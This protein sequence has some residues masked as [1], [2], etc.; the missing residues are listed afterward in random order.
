[1]RSARSLRR[2]CFFV[3]NSK[4]PK[5]PVAK[6]ILSYFLC[7]PEA[8]DS[9]TEIARWRLTQE[10]VRRTVED[11]QAALDWLL[12]EGYVRE[13]VRAGTESLFR[14]NSAS[15]KEAELFLE[16]G[17]LSAHSPE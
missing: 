14:L 13:E 17:P 11:T 16:E 15:R 8:A 7:H 6:E 1:M 9:L 10:T 4:R 5:L 2:K 12:S 3:T